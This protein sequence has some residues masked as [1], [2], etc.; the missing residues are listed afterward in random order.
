MQLFGDMLEAYESVIMCAGALAKPQF[1]IL[2]S[3]MILMTIM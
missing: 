3:L 2:Q 1:R